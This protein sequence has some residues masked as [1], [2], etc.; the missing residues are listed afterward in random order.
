MSLWSLS[1]VPAY[2]YRGD[3]YSLETMRLKPNHLSYGL[4]LI[5]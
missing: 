1:K 5:V 2:P 4:L 3:T